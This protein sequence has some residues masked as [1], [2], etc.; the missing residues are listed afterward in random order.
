MSVSF[1]SNEATGA[2]SAPH[3]SLLRCFSE[4]VDSLLYP[5]GDSTATS[6]AFRLPYVRPAAPG[7]DP[8]GGR[9]FSL[10]D[11]WAVPAAREPG[12][13][14]P[15]HEPRL[16]RMAVPATIGGTPA[17]RIRGMDDLGIGQLT[18]AHRRRGEAIFHLDSTDASWTRFR[19]DRPL[20]APPQESMRT[21]PAGQ[22][23]EMDRPTSRQDY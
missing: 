8:E 13:P 21:L 17:S 16:Y 9:S 15:Q 23:P 14:F 22:P 5:L 20:T 1:P 11:A 2:T 7:Q 3:H 12:S 18:D 19:D 4:F 10:R 6:L